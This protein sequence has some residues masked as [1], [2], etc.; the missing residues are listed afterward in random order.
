MS[1]LCSY[2][3]IHV[4]RCQYF[5]DFSLTKPTSSLNSIINSLRSACQVML[6]YYMLYMYVY[7]P[8]CTCICRTLINLCTNIFVKLFM[9]QVCNYAHMCKSFSWN[10]LTCRK[11]ILLPEKVIGMFSIFCNAQICQVGTGTFCVCIG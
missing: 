7:L 5:S 10:M 6:G 4:C 8:V 1:L 9:Y 3:N 2:M 11:T